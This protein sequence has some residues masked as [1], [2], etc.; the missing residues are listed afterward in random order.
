MLNRFI[1]FSLLIGSIH[2]SVQK[3]LADEMAKYGLKGAYAQYL[4][5][6]YKSEDKMTLVEL[7]EKCDN[8]KAAVSRAVG[9]MVE[10][11]LIAKENDSYRAG[12]FL[13]PEGIKAAE[14]VCNRA[15]MAVEAAGVT[16]EERE[17]F[18]LSLEKLEQNLKI[19][20]KKGI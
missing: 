4:I 19:I 13:T 17:S 20:S 8:D 11:G 9:N 2:K 10:K 7:T 1:K 18:Y 12:L 5:T 6:L 3:I 15:K 16:E 14:F